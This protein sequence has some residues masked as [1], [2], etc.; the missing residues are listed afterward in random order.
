MVKKGDM[1]LLQETSD[2]S[3]VV[4]S[5]AIVTVVHDQDCVD[6]SVLKKGWGN[7]WPLTSVQREGTFDPSEGQASLGWLE[8]DTEE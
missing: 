8:R 5:P 6:L 1:V 3:E 7:I 4:Q 2:D